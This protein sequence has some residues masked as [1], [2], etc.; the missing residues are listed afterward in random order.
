MCFNVNHAL[1]DVQIVRL[2]LVFVRP[3]KAIISSKIISV[4]WLVVLGTIISRMC[5]GLVLLSVRLVWLLMHII[6]H[7]VCKDTTY[8]HSFAIL[9][10]QSERTVR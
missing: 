9:C 8:Q 4:Y 10:A 5:V 3:V 6:A 7:N 2:L 1:Q